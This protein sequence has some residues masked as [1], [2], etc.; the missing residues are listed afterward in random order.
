MLNYDLDTSNPFKKYISIGKELKINFL[1]EHL[2]KFEDALTGKFHINSNSLIFEIEEKEFKEGKFKIG[3][4]VKIIMEASSLYKGVIINY[5]SKYACPY[6]IEREN[7]DCF[8]SDEI[9]L[10]LD[11]GKKEWINY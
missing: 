3:D 7:G 11:R 9:S 8:Y 5:D 2:K 10:E 4:K 6:K 1:I